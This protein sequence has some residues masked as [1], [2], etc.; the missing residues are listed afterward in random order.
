MSRHSDFRRMVSIHARLSHA[1]N[2]DVIPLLKAHD[3]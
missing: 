2:G 3:F 1:G